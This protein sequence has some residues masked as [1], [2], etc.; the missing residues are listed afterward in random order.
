MNRD[1][2][3]NNLRIIKETHAKRSEKIN[4]KEQQDFFKWLID[5]NLDGY[6]K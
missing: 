2:F 4:H 3:E 5:N 1:I 6:L